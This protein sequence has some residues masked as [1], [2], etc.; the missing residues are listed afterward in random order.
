MGADL[1]NEDEYNM[2]KHIGPTVKISR[3][4]STN[5]GHKSSAT[6]V[7]RR[8]NQSPGQ[9]GTGRRRRSLSS[10][11]KQL[12]E[13]QKA[14][15]VYGIRERQ[16][17]SYVDKASRMQG[18]SGVNLQ[19]LLEQRLDNVVYRL[20]FAITRPQA[21][22]MV[23]HGLFTVNGKK[24]NIPSY[25]VSEGDT[26][27]VKESKKGKKIF[28]N[29]SERLEKHDT[30]SWLSLDGATLSGKVLGVPDKQDRELAFDVKLITEY[31]SSR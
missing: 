31:Y 8:L 16:F 9:H 20:G 1:L 26:I 25:I 30:P 7:A 17:R 6:K 21:R 11:G 4:F 12:A 27:V 24:M 19:N 14:K 23:S 5:L 3:R 2:G 13:K 22:Q 29:L 28:D 15:F 10:F 18:D